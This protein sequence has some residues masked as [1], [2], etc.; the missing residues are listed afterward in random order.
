MEAAMGTV[1]VMVLSAGL[2]VLGFFLGWLLSSKVSHSKTYRAELTAEKIVEDAQKEAESMKR[3]AVLEARDEMHQQRL[4]MEHEIEQ[5]WDQAKHT[6]MKLGSR[7]RQLDKRADLLNHKEKIISS[8]EGDLARQQDE[9]ASRA[10]DLDERVLE[11][12]ARL[13]QI[14]GLTKDEAKAILMA[15]LEDEARREA[16]CG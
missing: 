3:T 10:Q 15:N 8:R 9:V 12:N 13:E 11:H 7:E 1:T 2:L 5:K 14:A 16:A 6:E 4:G